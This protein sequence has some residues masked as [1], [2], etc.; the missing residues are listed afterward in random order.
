MKTVKVRNVEIGAGMPKICVPIT[1]RTEEE[2]VQQAQMLR[3]CA[4][5]LAEWRADWYENVF[6]PAEVE[7]MLKILREKL[8]EMPLLFTFR[9]AKEGGEKDVEP[10]AYVELNRNVIRTRLADLVDVEVF[11][12][13][14]NVQDT[15]TAE[16][17][18]EAAHG[19]GVKVVASSHDFE[20][21]PPEERIISR[22]R[23]MQETGADIVKIAVMPQ[24]RRDVLTL[25]SATQEMTEKYAKCPVITMA[26]GALG[27]ISRLGGGV[28]GSAVTFGTAGRASAPG[29]TDA[30]ELKRALELIHGGAH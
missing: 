23:R 10:D 9:T 4:A 19:C 20:K 22:L 11:G 18:I 17:I 26:M 6:C 21:T 8:G 27:V 29:Q 3:Q 28:F 15:G 13:K 16:E 30:A 5:D 1:G 12:G 24:N 2:I 25:L 14:E 7:K